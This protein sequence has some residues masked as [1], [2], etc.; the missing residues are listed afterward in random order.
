MGEK[1]LSSLPNN[2]QTSTTG[3]VSSQM[4]SSEVGWSM[5]GKDQHL[6]PFSPLRTLRCDKLTS[7]FRA[8]MTKAERAQCSPSWHLPLQS[9]E[10]LP[11]AKLLWHLYIGL[12]PRPT[13]HY[14]LGLRN[15]TMSPNIPGVEGL[16][17]RACVGEKA[18][19]GC[20]HSWASWGQVIMCS[21]DRTAALT[22][23]VQPTHLV[24]TCA[25]QEAC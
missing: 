8:Y 20:P 7:G 14:Q 16:S 4:G 1:T 24:S 3:W 5:G 25:A 11:S 9:P 6:S 19:Q 2:W 18:L 13:F 23:T 22:C 17:K 10:S 12:G 21:E 15:L